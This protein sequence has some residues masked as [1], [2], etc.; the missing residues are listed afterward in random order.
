MGTGAK[1]KR[2]NV[3]GASSSTSKSKSA[4]VV[5]CECCISTFA[6]NDNK[7]NRNR[8]VLPKTKTK[9]KPIEQPKPT[10]T[11][12]D[13]NAVA[14]Q[15]KELVIVG[16][17]PHALSLVLRLLEPEADLLS[18]KER[19][20]KADFESR[21]RPIAEVRKHIKNLARGPTAVLAKKKPPKKKHAIQSDIDSDPSPLSLSY[22]R[23]NVMVIDGSLS[24]DKNDTKSLHGWMSG[25]NQQ[26]DALNIHQLRSPIS[27]HADPY[28]HRSLQL[29]GEMTKRDHEL[30]PLEHLTKTNGRWDF[31]GP[32]NAP[33]TKLFADFHRQLITG[34]GVQ[35]MVTPGNV[36]RIRCKKNAWF[37]VTTRDAVTGNMT[38]VTTPRVVCA[39]GPASRIVEPLMSRMA[40][41]PWQLPHRVLR[42]TQIMDFLTKKDVPKQKLSVLI[43]GG[44]VTSAHLAL[45]AANSD[46][47]PWCD[48]VTL[49]QRSPTKERQFDLDKAWMGPARG[50]RLESFWSLSHKE[51]AIRLKEERGGGSIHPE[52]LEKMLKKSNTPNGKLSIVE[53]AELMD[54]QYDYRQ[55]TL[56][57]SLDD[58]SP[59]RAFDMI[60]L[61][62]GFE[63]QLKNYPFLKHLQKD[64]PID[65]VTGLPVLSKDLTWRKATEDEDTE[66]KEQPWKYEARNRLWMMGPL[67]GLELGPDALNLMGARHGAVRVAKALRA[68][69]SRSL[70]EQP[71]IE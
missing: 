63:I 25:W 8:E 26:F 62:T 55:D 56:L 2:A 9:T 49:L 3:D 32:Y 16:A 45:T 12:T 37:E 48:S 57:V 70:L 61:V 6:F 42:G 58:G 15:H 33:S 39:V 24:P 20:I 38:I 43:V 52:V 10:K 27:A 51:R 59:V 44:G 65:K 50:N 71:T 68:D 69:I 4:S 67:A 29:F 36:E 13:E 19:H 31:H 22:V 21:Q 64:L 18:E 23:E 60:W 7:E 54:V 53:E 11:S 47:S 41:D 1:L 28:D 66:S 35:D 34:Y 5:D 40:L 30:V 14:R 46:C 17:G